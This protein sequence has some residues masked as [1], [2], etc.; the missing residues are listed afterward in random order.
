MIGRLARVV[1]GLALAAGI[2]LVVGELLARA[3][4]VVD[5]LNGYGRFVYR[6]GP[7][8]DLPY[9]LRPG[10]VTTVFGTPVRVNRLGLRGPEAEIRP[11]SGVHRVLV[12]GDSVVFGQGVAEDETLPAD[13]GRRLN[14]A[15]AGE[16]EVLNAGVPGYDAVAEAR[17]LEA[18][19]LAL[20]PETVVVGTSL[21]DYDVAPQYSPLGILTRKELD[22]RTPDLVDRSEL[23]TLLRWLPGGLRGSLG[24]QLVARLPAGTTTDEPGLARL[25]EQTHLGFYHRP[26]PAEWERLRAAYA[27]F[28][29]LAAAHHLR[30]LVAIFP[31]SYQVGPPDPDLTP[32]RKLLEL[33]A[34]VQLRCIDLQPIFATA[35]GELFSNA[36]HPNARGYAVAAGAI[37]TVL[38]GW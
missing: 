33:C 11:R 36:Q 28:G 35:G 16:Y 3:L 23:L 38:L 8:V 19:G 7:S 4:D 13:L 20:A 1:L 25:V 27:D 9:L 6:A 32:Q 21:N 29:R 17:L 12:L 22:R 30:L 15:N 5:R 34:E 14:A 31:E 24:Y 37:A 2:F 18:S 26:D 10:V